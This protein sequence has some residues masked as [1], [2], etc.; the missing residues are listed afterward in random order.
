MIVEPLR[1]GEHCLLAGRESAHLV[2][3]NAI[4]PPAALI[5]WKVA[6]PGGWTCEL[7]DQV[8]RERPGGWDAYDIYLNGDWIGSS[9]V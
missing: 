5:Q 9:E 2:V 7:L 6:P 4:H 8:E 1:E 3:V